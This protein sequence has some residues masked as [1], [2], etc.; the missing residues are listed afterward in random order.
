VGYEL[1]QAIQAELALDNPEGAIVPVELPPEMLE[2]PEVAHKVAHEVATEMVVAEAACET[3]IVVAVPPGLNGTLKNIQAIQRWMATVN[4][5]SLR[6][7]RG[8]KLSVL[9]RHEFDIG[10]IE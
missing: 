4:A 3:D 2:D 1:I 7:T 8:G 6:L 9:A 10:E 5:E